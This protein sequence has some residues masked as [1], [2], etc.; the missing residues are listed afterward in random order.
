MSVFEHDKDYSQKM[1]E[2]DRLRI[3]E[4][5]MNEY[6]DEIKRLVF[7]YVSNHA[8]ADDISQEVFLK[9]YQ[10]IDQFKGESEL[11]SWI[12]RIAI[13]KSKDH[14]RSWKYRQQKLKDKME[15]TFKKESA[16]EHQTPEHI[17]IED[18]EANTLME[19]VYELPVK[20]REVIIL[21]YFEQ[22]STKEIAEVLE[23]NLNT[24][25]A[26]LKRGRERLKTFLDGNG[27]EQFG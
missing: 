17:S 23:T 5:C 8:D 6:G 10:K 27:G 14:L 3:V 12:Y 25:K 22:L 4:E 11:K 15:R 20:Y 1:T 16:V 13:N 24:V 2:Q 21:H 18:E 19:H 26:R 9:V 7:T